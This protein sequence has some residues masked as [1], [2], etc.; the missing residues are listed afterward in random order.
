[1]T[2]VVDA[3]VAPLAIR[4]LSESGRLELDWADGQITGVTHAALRSHCR[5]GECVARRRVHGSINVTPEIRLVGV[6]PYGANAVRLTF[7]D[8]HGRGIYP[9]AWLKSLAAQG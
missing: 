7:S 5:C 3:G 8:G 4:V 6:T 2:V 1:M 9:F